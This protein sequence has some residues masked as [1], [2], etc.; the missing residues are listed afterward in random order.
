MAIPFGAFTTAARDNPYG[1]FLRAATL[2]PLPLTAVCLSALWAGD[3]I[4]SLTNRVGCPL[5]FFVGQ[6]ANQG[7]AARAGSDGQAVSLASGTQI[8]L[9]AIVAAARE[10]EALR[11]SSGKSDRPAHLAGD[12]LTEHLIQRAA[13]AAQE[14]PP[15]VA[16]KAFLLGVGIGLDDSKVLRD[17]PLIGPLHRQVESEA[18]RK[19]RLSVLGKPTVHGRRDLAKHF[20]VSIALTVPLGP[21]TAETLG[22]LKEVRDAQGGTG[23]SF[24]DLQADLA[25]V[26]FACAVQKGRP[27]LAALATSFQLN[28]FVPPPNG[29]QEGLVWEAFTAAY[30]S[31][32]DDRF[33]RQLATIRKRILALQ[34]RRNAVD[35]QDGR[36]GPTR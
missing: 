25:G 8:V 21:Q 15:A 26:S 24:V 20:A 30:G 29:L 2:L 13:A 16:T 31:T 28:D 34:D 36:D 23:F 32:Q 19:E 27:S 6:L 33:L 18:Q 14:L 10:N 17:N 4:V 12:R 22:I 35:R 1:M 7:E 9:S 5:T 3:D 11:R